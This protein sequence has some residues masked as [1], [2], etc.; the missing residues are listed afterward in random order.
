MFVKLIT[1]IVC[2][3]ISISIT[4]LLEIKDNYNE[5]RLNSSIPICFGAKLIYLFLNEPCRV[6][7]FCSYLVTLGSVL[8][9]CVGLIQETSTRLPLFFIYKKKKKI[10]F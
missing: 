1:I 4:V 8:C 2:D 6:R 7:P 3:C 5:Q 10:T 9:L